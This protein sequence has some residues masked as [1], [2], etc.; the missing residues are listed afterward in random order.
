LS[1]SVFTGS[2]VLKYQLP[3][4]SDVDISIYDISGRM[5]N[6]IVSG[7]K[8]A[9][10]Y[11]ININASNYSAGTYFIRMKSDEYDHA[12]RMTIVR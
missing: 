10:I 9:G 3:R 2:S 4:E 8:K 1:R 5:V 6:N 7:V 11:K 12:E